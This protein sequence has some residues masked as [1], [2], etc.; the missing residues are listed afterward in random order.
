[1]AASHPTPGEQAAVAAQCRM[2]LMIEVT[3]D[4]LLVVAGEREEGWGRGC[5][6]RESQIHPRAFESQLYHTLTG[7]HRLGAASPS[8]ASAYTSE[9]GVL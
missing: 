9:D 7:R 3:P 4:I 2:K 6:K 8:V 5:R 1:M